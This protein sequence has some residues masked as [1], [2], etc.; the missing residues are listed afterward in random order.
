MEWRRWAPYGV[1]VLIIGIALLLWR[2]VVRDIGPSPYP[3]LLIAIM[4][5]SWYG[6]RGPGLLATGLSLG[7]AVLVYARPLHDHRG[8]LQLV[9]FLLLALAICWMNHEHLRSLRRERH[10][11]ERLEYLAAERSA[12]LRQMTEAIITTD[13]TSHVTFMN[14]AAVRLLGVERW[15]GLSPRELGEAVQVRRLD[16]SPGAGEEPLLD[17]ALAGES[18]AGMEVAL[19]RRDGRRLVVQVNTARVTAPDGTVLG[20]VASLRDAT[21]DRDLARASAQRQPLLSTPQSGA[22]SCFA[23][24]GERSRSPSC[25]SPRRMRH[26]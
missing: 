3:L 2:V 20:T 16:G 7:I 25:D 26:H 17:R 4:A 8:L 19:Q 11:R 22:S 13:A 15:N 18:I 1:S 14:D 21:V 24:A 9:L 23:A 6:G 12:M 10:A 5:A